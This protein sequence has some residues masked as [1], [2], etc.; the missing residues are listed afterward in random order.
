MILWARHR[1]LAGQP[2]DTVSQALEAM[3]SVRK[4][5]LPSSMSYWFGAC[6][7]A[8]VLNSAKRYK[9]GE[10]M[11]RET[12]AA[13]EANRLPEID[14]RRAESLLEL[15]KALHGQKRDREAAPLLKRS[16]MIYDTS[17]HPTGGKWARDVLSE[18]KQGNPRPARGIVRRPSL[19]HRVNGGHDTMW[20]IG[21]CSMNTAHR[22]PVDPNL[23]SGLAGGDES[24]RLKAALAIGS[25]PEP[26]LVDTLIARCAIE[27]NFYVRDMLTW[28]LTRY[29]SE[30]TV[31]RLIDEL[32]SER[33]QARSQALHTLSKIK[34][35]RAWPAITRSLLRDADDE[36]A[37]S[38]WRAAVV[39]VPDGQK[40]NLAEDL[41]TQ[42]GRGNRI[43]LLSLSRALV[44]LGEDVIGRVLQSG[45]ASND[46]RVRD[47][48]RATER[49]LHE[50]DA[51][52]MPS[53]EEAKRIIALGK[54]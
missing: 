13:I 24:T 41:A 12:F 49:L 50:P 43:V 3:N 42:L 9:E 40:K 11:A 52:S 39:L 14:G 51:I 20:L 19:L 10:S 2:A 29:P 31:P 28:A 23:I 46:Q 37:R 1:V 26:G 18:I 7:T 48:A 36:V 25:S 16:E 27:P 38:A 8:F 6:N 22:K 15:G 47:H 44:A 35:A 33:A 53:I 5:F 32:S 45:L 34:D 17:H 4:H 21:R 30:V 54:E